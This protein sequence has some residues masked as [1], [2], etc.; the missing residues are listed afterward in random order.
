MRVKIRDGLEL[1]GTESIMACGPAQLRAVAV[2][3]VATVDGEVSDSLLVANYVDEIDIAP[4]LQQ[5]M[6]RELKK[7][8]FYLYG[9][10]N[11]NCAITH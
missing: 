9:E 1:V 5:T 10:L 4:S 11:A 7:L 3:L 8:D 6:D 2:V